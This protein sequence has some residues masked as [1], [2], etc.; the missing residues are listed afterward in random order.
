MLKTPRQLA[1]GGEAA[2]EKEARPGR[3]RLD[4][5]GVSHRRKTAVDEHGAWNERSE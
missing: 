2:Y 3:L 5:H 1:M 4:D